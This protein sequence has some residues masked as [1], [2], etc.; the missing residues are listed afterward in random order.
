MGGMRE[1]TPTTIVALCERVKTLVVKIQV[2]LLHV[3]FH[4][5]LQAGQMQVGAL[6]GGD[7]VRGAAIWRRVCKMV[8]RGSRVDDGPELFQVWL[9]LRY[10]RIIIAP[11]CAKLQMQRENYTKQAK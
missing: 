6:P 9:R 2:A 3:L 7:H 8:N 10:L 5:D 1:Q 11:H 4:D